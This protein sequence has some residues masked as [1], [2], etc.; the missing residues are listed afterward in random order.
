[1]T[2]KCVQRIGKFLS[3]VMLGLKIASLKIAL[4]S[5]MSELI[6][7]VFKRE[8]QYSTRMPLSA[9]ANF[10]LLLH[11]S[12]FYYV[13]VACSILVAGNNLD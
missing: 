10:I 13:N 2:K 9:L 6:T 3:A 8:K 12:C 4:G 1:M 11:F 5:K 7:S